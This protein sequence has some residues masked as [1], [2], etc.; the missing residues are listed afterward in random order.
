MKV[1][2][3]YIKKGQPPKLYKY[4]ELHLSIK[5]PSKQQL[6]ISNLCQIVPRK[7]FL[8]RK[9]LHSLLFE[10]YEALVC[11]TLGFRSVQILVL[12][13]YLM[14]LLDTG[15]QGHRLLHQYMVSLCMLLFFPH[16]KSPIYTANKNTGKL[17]VWLCNNV[18][19]NTVVLLHFEKIHSAAPP[20]SNCNHTWTILW[21][22][23]IHWNSDS[24][25]FW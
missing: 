6:S 20:R 18:N 11:W 13:V 24:A 10:M 9:E 19:I 23:K 2:P 3:T 25:E 21:G 15:I 22:Q 1:V 8:S 4:P 7:W 17:T 16:K 12:M 14:A 5:K